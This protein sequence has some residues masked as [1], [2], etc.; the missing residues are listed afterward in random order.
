MLEETDGKEMC[1]GKEKKDSPLD[2]LY[3][4]RQGKRANQQGVVEREGP[5]SKP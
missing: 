5:L 4:P 1:A 3:S 2:S